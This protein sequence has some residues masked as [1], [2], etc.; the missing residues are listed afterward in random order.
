MASRS[1]AS[2]PASSR[3]AAIRWATDRRARVPVPERDAASACRGTPLC[4]AGAN[5]NGS[6]F[7]ICEAPQPQLDGDYTIFGEC[8][9]LDVV[10]DITHVPTDPTDKPLT[11]II[12]TKVTVTRCAP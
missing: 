8:A 2:S 5:T 1:T 6:Q 9:P 7:Y 3:K 10:T 4:H 11:P 12:I